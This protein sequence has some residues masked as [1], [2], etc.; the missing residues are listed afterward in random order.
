[1]SVQR[2]LYASLSA[3]LISLKII[4]F[5]SITGEINDDTFYDVVK[6]D[7]LIGEGISFAIREKSVDNR[8]IGEVIIY[9]FTYNGSAEIGVRVEKESQGKGI[10]TKAFKLGADFAENVLKVKIKA[11]CYKEN[12]KS[13][14]TILSCG[15]N[16][17]SEDEEF[18]Y[19]AR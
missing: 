3:S 10:G 5:S 7:R 12:I 9:N 15:F 4:P 14:E 16:Q 18:Y 11:K 19:F 1:M 2:F 17:V 13:K 6:F 8:L